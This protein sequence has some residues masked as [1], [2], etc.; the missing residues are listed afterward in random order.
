M[1]NSPLK[2]K[3][4]SPVLGIKNTGQKMN[5][6][7]G[8]AADQALYVKIFFLNPKKIKIRVQNQKVESFFHCVILYSNLSDRFEREP[9]T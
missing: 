6:D 2:V 1:N 5:L 7:K 9:I 4:G 8:S 3:D